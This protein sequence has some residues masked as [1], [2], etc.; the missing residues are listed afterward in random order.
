MSN[1]KYGWDESFVIDFSM[2][3]GRSKTAVSTRRYLSQMEH[4]YFD[5]T[6]AHKMAEREDCLV[7]E[8][9]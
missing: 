5:K 6:T 8:F 9:Y 3:N 7:Y 2:Q 4:M 1:N